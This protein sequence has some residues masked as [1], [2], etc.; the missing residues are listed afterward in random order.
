MRKLRGARRAWYEGDVRARRRARR[1]REAALAATAS[2]RRFGVLTLATALLGCV[3]HRGTWSTERTLAS[4][5][6]GPE[7]EL[8]LLANVA[9]DD[10]HAKAVAER[11]ETRL[12]NDR[13][14]VI[15]WLG[16]VA[17]APMRSST[18]RAV[19]RGP[20]CLPMEDAWSSRGSAR[21]AAATEP[22]S[23]QGRSFAAMGV[24]DH[25]CGHRDALKSTKQ[26]W[27]MPGD[28]YVVRV[29]ADG[30]TRVWARCDDDGCHAEPEPSR[31]EPSALALADLVVVD[32][33]PWLHPHGE[34]E[35][36]RRD[37][38]RVQ[39]LEALL[40]LVAEAPPEAGPPR[41]LVSSVPVEAAG[42]H[43]MGA[44]W[45]EATFHALPS[46]LQERLV[47]GSFAGV[48]AAHDRSLVLTPDLFDP[49]KRADR[50]WLRRPLFQVQAGAVTRPNRRA[51]MALRPRRIR[52]S[53]AYRA[54]VLSEHPGFAVVRLRPDDATLELHARRGRR[55]QMTSTTVPLRPPPHPAMT[56]SPQMAP[57]RDCPP[58][59]AT[60]R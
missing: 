49:I 26:P 33:S 30:S 51:G 21:L 35:P 40:T 56:P 25:R 20:R 39:E 34:P 5:H 59:P 9:P 47:D 44:L 57:C 29:H 4:E 55:W 50:A 22:L 16:N 3:A 45:P 31:T 37:E 7:V 52:E 6:P 13:P 12:A 1:R 41:L 58:V 43:G 10:R 36:R 53:Q 14:R 2:A 17:A 60:E 18:P 11:I 28:H 8:V 42:E 23:S 38:R 54:D 48:L 27:S 32:L 15:V 46:F 19:A 24:L